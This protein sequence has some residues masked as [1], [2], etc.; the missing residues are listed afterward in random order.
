MLENVKRQKISRTSGEHLTHH[1]SESGIYVEGVVITIFGFV[2]VYATDDFWSLE[3]IWDQHSYRTKGNCTNLPSNLAL[4]GKASAFA[5]KIIA[6]Q[7][8]NAANPTL[9]NPVEE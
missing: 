5:K 8:L 9:D 1:T 7:N 6:S 4:S 3:F 2:R